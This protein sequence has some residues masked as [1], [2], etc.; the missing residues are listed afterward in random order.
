[1]REFKCMNTLF[2]EDLARETDV[3]ISTVHFCR[4]E[5]NETAKKA[6]KYGAKVTLG[7]DYPNYNMSVAIPLN[8]LESLRED[9]N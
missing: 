5:F 4:F 6:T 7:C 8:Q 2:D 9:L 1:M 3:K